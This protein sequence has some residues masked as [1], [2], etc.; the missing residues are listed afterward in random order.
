MALESK[1]RAQILALSIRDNV[2]IVIHALERLN[3]GER[4]R[5]FPRSL[6]RAF[7][8]MEHDARVAQ[9]PL[10][11]VDALAQAKELSHDVLTND[12]SHARIEALASFASLLGAAAKPI[13]EGDEPAVDA[14]WASR[15]RELRVSEPSTGKLA[16]MIDDQDPPTGS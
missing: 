4:E 2:R 7:R 3:A 11:L 12:R 16:D 8:T 1:Q 15:L 13:E 5:T 6:S 9:A 14:L 10:P